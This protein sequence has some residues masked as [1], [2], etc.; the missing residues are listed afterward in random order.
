MLDRRQKVLST[1]RSIKDFYMKLTLLKAYESDACA[2]DNY[3]YLYEL[4]AQE[5]ALVEDIHSFKKF[6]VP[7]LV[8][9]KREPEI[10]SLLAEIEVLHE[11][12]L[13]DTIDIR[14]NLSSCLTLTRKRIDNLEAVSGTVSIPRPRAIDIRA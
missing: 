6:V 13:R 12:V 5:R 9:Y 10:G 7:D 1:L 3:D 8:Y 14:Q 4:T 2:D 11:K